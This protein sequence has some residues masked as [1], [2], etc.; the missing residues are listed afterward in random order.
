MRKIIFVSMLVLVGV[1][2]WGCGDRAH[3][4]DTSPVAPPVRGGELHAGE[5][6][7]EMMQAFE[8]RAPLES[9]SSMNWEQWLETT[10]NSMEDVYVAHDIPFDRE[11][12][13]QHIVQMVKIFGALKQAT[14]I[15][16]GMLRAS[17]TPEADLSRLV[18]QLEKWKLVDKKTAATMLEFRVDDRAAARAES[19]T[20]G[21]LR[22]VFRIGAS[23]REFWILHERRTPVQT[24]LSDTEDPPCK[25]CSIGSTV[26]DY[27][28]GLVGRLICGGDPACRAGMAAAASLLYNL[29]TG[30]CDNHPCG[31]DNFWPPVIWP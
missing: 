2:L 20:D 1:V 21:A 31:F 17:E 26:S 18:G 4:S 22:D 28:G 19:I 9:I 15:E 14:G 5:L 12:M 16:P 11:A 27:L 29:A 8:S 7:N 6:H 10:L 30:Y 25:K 3:K 24:T 23:S 13:S